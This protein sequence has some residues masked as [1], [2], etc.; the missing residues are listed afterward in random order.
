M[1][2]YLT[3]AW[4]RHLLRHFYNEILA[5]IEQLFE[6]KFLWNLMRRIIYFQ[7]TKQLWLRLGNALTNFF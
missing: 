6:Q 1:W 5:V 2:L 4:W 7:M 3:S